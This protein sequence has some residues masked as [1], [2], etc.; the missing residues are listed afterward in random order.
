[1]VRVKRVTRPFRTQENHGNKCQ[2]GEHDI[3]GLFL[4]KQE[5]LRIPAVF[6]ICEAAQ[7]TERVSVWTQIDTI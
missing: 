1:M 5:I 6:T 7:V 4:S 3:V 2:R